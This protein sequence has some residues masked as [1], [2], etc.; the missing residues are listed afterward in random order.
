MDTYRHITPFE[1][2][3]IMALHEPGYSP[4]AIATI[5]KRHR[6]TIL[7]E[8]KRNSDGRTYNA[9]KAQEQ[10]DNRRLVC[11]RKRKLDDPE[12]FALVKDRFL[13]QHWSPEQIQYRLRHEGSPHSISYATIYRGIYAGRFNDPDRVKSG[14]QRLRHR[15][16]QRRRKGDPTRDNFPVAHELSERPPE[17]QARARIG[18]WEA[19]TVAGVVGGAVLLTLVDRKSRYLHC[20]RLE[21]KTAD[22]VNAGIFKVLAG[23]PVHGITPD[24]G[25]EFARH[26][27]VAEAL[28]VKIYIPPPYQ[29]WQRGTNENTNGLLR[30]YFPKHQDIAQY[31]DDYIEKAVLALNNRPRKCLQWR[32]PYEVYFEEVLHLV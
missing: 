18:D 13:K 3:C 4:A 27:V 25:K 21:K 2:G 9:S 23:Q 10:Y 30:E 19:D 14:K 1:R 20:V 17:A 12:L 32:T 6:S 28:G 31:S 8:L 26:A 11:H 7:R 15:G 5:L 24:R 16:K 29:P 22:N